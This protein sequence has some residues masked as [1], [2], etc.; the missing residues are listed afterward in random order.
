MIKKNSARSIA[1]R[2][3]RHPRDMDVC[4]GSYDHP[5]SI[6]LDKAIRKAL[7]EFQG[8][9]WSPAVYKAIRNN[10]QGK[11]FFF[12]KNRESP[13]EEADANERLSRMKSR[14]EAKRQEAY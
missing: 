1:K 11:R 8:Q 12:R 9:A 5:G 4:Y 13:W 6:D 2:G 7:Q 3:M 10:L 14:F